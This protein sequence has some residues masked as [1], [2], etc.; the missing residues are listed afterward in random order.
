[1]SSS[2]VQTEPMRKEKDSFHFPKDQILP[3][4][5]IAVVAHNY[6]IKQRLITVTEDKTFLCLNKNLR[7]IGKR[8]WIH[9]LS[10]L[11]TMLL[12]LATSDFDRLP[13]M[14]AELLKATFIVCS[15]IATAWLIWEIIHDGRLKEI[16][17]AI[18]D[19]FREFRAE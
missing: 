10:L 6:N 8:K 17:Q 18:D 9:P 11:V 15:G 4:P 16:P 1:M 7:F 12:A 5:D 2:N 19:I 14:N 3:T 13:W